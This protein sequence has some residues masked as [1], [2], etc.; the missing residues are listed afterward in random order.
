MHTK[1]LSKIQ[2][3]WLHHINQAAKQKISMS[4]YAKQ[5]NLA[6]KGF[7]NARSALIQKGILP[8]TNNLL[9]PVTLTATPPSATTSCRITLC[10]GVIIELADVGI[11]DLLNSANQL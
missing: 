5:H 6:L 8:V 3:G 7:Y 1:P 11:S 9:T 2:Q 10:N 4:A